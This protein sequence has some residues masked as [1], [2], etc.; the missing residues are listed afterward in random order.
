L[1]PVPAPVSRS[2]QNTQCPAQTR[3][4]AHPAHPPCTTTIPTTRPIHAT[5]QSQGPSPP[6]AHSAFAA[7]SHPRTILSYT[8][9]KHFVTPPV[10]ADLCVRPIVD[11]L[12]HTRMNL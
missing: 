4:N 6:R 12:Q 9:T 3:E 7:R 2:C 11:L 5:K 1:G 10:G 8:L